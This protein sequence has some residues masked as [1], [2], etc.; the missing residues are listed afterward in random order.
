LLDSG[1]LHVARFGEDGSGEWVP[2]VWGEHPELTPKNGFESQGDVVLRC[3]E[4]AD[5]V[6]A[7]PM[8]RPEDIAVSPRTSKVYMACTNNPDREGG[9]VESA[10][11]L[12]STD[13]AGSNPRIPNPWGHI[14][15][16]S[17][18][19][20]DASATAFRWEIFLL[21]GDP[22]QGQFLTTLAPD[23]A[24]L[25]ADSTY[26]AGYPNP[27]D[28]SAFAAPDNL[29][30]DESGNLWITTDGDQPRGN[31]DGCYVCPTEGKDRGAVRQFM[32]GPVGAEISGCEVTP[33]GGSLLLGIQH[34]GEGGSVEAPI[35][36]W[37][38]GGTSAPR[39][40]VVAIRPQDR[41]RTLIG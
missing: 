16:L 20:V 40:S 10:G 27:D 36:S 7:T 24:G 32:S 28:L 21:A 13:S 30:F 34:P 23:A 9:E 8:D 41:R 37:P 5:L 2:L 35:S 6:G 18:D 11:R 29:T 25:D 38:E 12:V 31:N 39:P 4:A 17:E 14:V 1:T 3:R 33:D 26:F 15:E 22:A 19:G